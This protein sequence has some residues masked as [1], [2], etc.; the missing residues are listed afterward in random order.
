MSSTLISFFSIHQNVDSQGKT[1]IDWWELLWLS[2]CLNLKDE[3]EQKV[4]MKIEKK[5]VCQ[6]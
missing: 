4:L 1:I 3:D 5:K 2:N 6:L